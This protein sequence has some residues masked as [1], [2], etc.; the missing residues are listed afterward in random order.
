MN[1][2]LEHEAARGSPQKQDSQ[3]NCAISFVVCFSLT[4]AS[5]LKT[6]EG[7][8]VFL[9]DTFALGPM[10]RNVSRVNVLVR[11]PLS[12]CESELLLFNSALIKG[13]VHTAFQFSSACLL[14]FFRPFFGFLAVWDF[15]RKVQSRIG[16]HVILFIFQNETECFQCSSI[17]H[18]LS[19]LCQR[20]AC[21]PRPWEKNCGN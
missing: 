19:K 11:F 14:N 17:L 4:K 21:I 3:W 5:N 8:H 10:A 2:R 15:F 18:S 1:P 9:M 16:K 12:S 20:A 13:R 7:T 6:S